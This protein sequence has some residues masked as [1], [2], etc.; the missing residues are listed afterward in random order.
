MVP[1]GKGFYIWK[2]LN[3]EEGDPESISLTAHKARLTHVLIKIANGIYNYNY[4][5]SRKEDLIGPVAD[6]LHRRNIQVWGWHYLF[7]DLPK[8]EAKVA[9]K[10]INSLPL[11]GYT[12]DA[13][14]EYKGKYTPCRI[15]MK[16][17]RNALPDFP[18]ALSSFRYPKYHRDLPWKDFLSYCDFNM[19]QVYWE[20]SHNPGYQLERSL[21]EFQTEVEVFRPIIPTGPVYCAG[22][23]CS[24]SEEIIEFM[25]KAISLE[26]S[27][28]N[29]WSWDYCRNKMPELWGTISA[30][31]W[32]TSPNP[33][34]DIPEKL[35]NS[36]NSQNTSAILNLYT[37]DAV[38]INA[39]RTIQGK[40]ALRK[41]YDD[42]FAN[43]LQ[44]VS[45]EIIDINGND[46]TRHFTWKTNQG[47]T[48]SVRGEDTIGISDNKIIYHYSSFS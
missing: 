23:W 17:F 41:Y 30:F 36:Y 3:C 19:P 31:N 4:D 7:G 28:V 9:I 43:D 44:G 35:I 33:E 27:A 32:P 48:D 21:N 20:K 6:A 16:E 42:L 18:M 12:V 15:F 10:Q 24:S 45:F 5:A 22:G 40:S 8:N 37:E 26:M 11:D 47:N 1:K 39:T 14:S 2:I 13:E 38:H 46:Q 25:N 34:K 29:F